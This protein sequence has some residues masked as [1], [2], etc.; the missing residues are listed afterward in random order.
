MKGIDTYLYTLFYA[1]ISSIC[2]NLY[3]QCNLNI[4]MLVYNKK[5]IQHYTIYIDIINKYKSLTKM[6][7]YL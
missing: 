4:N 1:N 6:L 2:F 5:Q 3:Y 7:L